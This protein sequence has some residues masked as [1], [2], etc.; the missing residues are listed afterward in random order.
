MAKKKYYGSKGGMISEDHSA[1]ANLPQNVI[2]KSYPE[3][4]YGMRQQLDDTI[5]GIDQQMNDDARKGRGKKGRNP[6]RY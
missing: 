1:F 2:M 3:I 5:T 6:K 4:V